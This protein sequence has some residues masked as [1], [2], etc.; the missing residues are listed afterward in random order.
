MNK[1]DLNIEF[2]RAVQKQDLDEV[3][4]ILKLNKT[5]KA[6]EANQKSHLQKLLKKIARAN[7]KDL[8]N[9]K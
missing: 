4:R 1:V 5:L 7:Q 8:C 6:K 2:M 9:V 3:E